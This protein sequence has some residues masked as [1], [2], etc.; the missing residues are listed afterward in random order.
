ML[1][2]F[3]VEAGVT[4][5]NTRPVTI[6]VREPSADSSAKGDRTVFVELTV[7]PTSVFVTE[8]LTA[9]LTIGMRTVMYGGKT[10]NINP[11]ELVDRRSSNLSVFSS[12]DR[13][14]T[15]KA[16]H[17]DSNGQSH[18]YDIVRLTKTVRAEEV[19]DLAIGPIFLKLRYPTALRRG[20]FGRME[21]TNSRKEIARAEALIVNVEGPPVE[22]RPAS[23]TG[24]IGGYAMDVEAKP[25][26]VEQGQPV[27][28]SV[29]I[30]GTPIEGVAGP[31]LNNHAELASR[32]DYAKDELVGDVRGRTKTFRRAVFPKQVGEQTVPP[33]EWTFFD[34]RTRKYITIE[35]DKIHLVVD[36]PSGDSTTLAT[37]DIG[38]PPD[39]ATR[40]TVLRGGISP[41]YIDPATVLA[42]QEIIWS[43]PWLVAMMGPPL[44]CLC[45][46][47]GARHRRRLQAD[48]GFGRRRRAAKNA[49]R[50]VTRAM[51][52]GQ[53][54]DA[55][56]GLAQSLTGY[57]ADRHNLPSGTLTPN[58]VEVLLQS[59]GLGTEL[60]NEITSFLQACDAARYAPMTDQGDFAKEAEADVR[61][62]IDAL[63][64]TRP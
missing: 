12:N 4:T 55:L 61:R 44:L 37:I 33:I 36:P 52:N 19:G 46:S 45:F 42:N 24:A 1:G 38:D 48:V 2:P 20:F 32:F 8:T 47:V 29:T 50:A 13:G 15:V 56:A 11:L 5:Y 22:G 60:S 51:S 30:K 26:R 63:E 14:R 10:Y 62:W 28:L 17:R 16:S 58:D 34:S 57:L 7:T 54:A 53:S 39:E 59:D 27:T 3:S 31:D 41:N 18:V 6:I 43:W 40:L 23:F 9:T 64:R 49:G 21:M 25:T 35:S